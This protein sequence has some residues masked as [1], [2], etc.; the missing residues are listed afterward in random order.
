MRSEAFWAEDKG[1]IFANG[2]RT[3][4]SGPRFVCSCLARVSVVKLLKDNSA[5]CVSLSYD[6]IVKLTLSLFYAFTFTFSLAVYKISA[7]CMGMK[8]SVFTQSRENV[9][10]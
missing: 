5:A 1:S 4:G 10:L 7:C 3:T 8:S 6:N 9:K 2:Q